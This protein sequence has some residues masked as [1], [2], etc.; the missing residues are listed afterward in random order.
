MICSPLPAKV[1]Q[2]FVI[3]K[4]E[5]VKAVNAIGFGGEGRNQGR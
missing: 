1:S 5:F 3:N 4:Q 2:A